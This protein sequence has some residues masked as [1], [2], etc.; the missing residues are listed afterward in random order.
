MPT[1]GSLHYYIKQTSAGIALVRCLDVH[2]GRR[3]A[4]PLRPTL[5]HTAGKDRASGAFLE[6][7]NQDTSGKISLEDPFSQSSLSPQY[8]S[9]K[10]FRKSQSEPR[11]ALTPIPPRPKSSAKAAARKN[12]P[13]TIQIAPDYSRLRR[14]ALSL[15]TPSTPST[16]PF[17]DTPPRPIP[18][19]VSGP[20]RIPV[21]SKPHHLSSIP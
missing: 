8:Q 18:Q 3:L 4:M 20:A 6:T 15:S 9:A 1:I 5:S 21:R 13:K 19:S 16:L 17:R 7:G 2:H 12:A 10:T 11:A 14:L